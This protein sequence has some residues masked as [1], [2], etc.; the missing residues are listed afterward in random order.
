M[1]LM[2]TIPVP[3]PWWKYPLW[4]PLPAVPRQPFDRV[5]LNV[6]GAGGVLSLHRVLDRRIVKPHAVVIGEH[7]ERTMTAR[8]KVKSGPPSVQVASTVRGQRRF[9]YGRLVGRTWRPHPVG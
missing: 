7:G 9:V 2:R 3:R 1:H 4:V 5:V 6:G 8:Y